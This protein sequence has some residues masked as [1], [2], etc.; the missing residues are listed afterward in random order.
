MKFLSSKFSFL[1]V[2]RA[3]RDA[4]KNFPQKLK[5]ARNKKRIWMFEKNNE[6]YFF[7]DIL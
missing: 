6:Y 1:N 2:T 3:A 4:V 5:M 7:P